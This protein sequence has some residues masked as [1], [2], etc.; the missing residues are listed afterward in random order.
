MKLAFIGF[1]EAARAFRQSI[2]EVAPETTFSAYDILLDSDSGDTMRRAIEAAGAKA[3]ATP[4]EAVL[5]AEWIICAV[6]ADQSHIAAA[7]VAKYLE[8]GQI[9][10]DVNSVAPKR[11]RDNANLVGGNA[12]TYVDMAIMAPVATNR[13]RTPVLVAGNIAGPIEKRLGELEFDFRIVGETPGQA[14]AIKMVRSLFVKGLEAITVETLLAAEA[15]GCA[16]EILSSLEGSYPGLGWPDF[17]EYEF[18]RTLTHGQR[19]EAEMRECAATLKGLGLH[20]ALAEAIAD[21]QGFMG[22]SGRSMPAES[23]L[24]EALPDLV[25][26]RRSLLQNGLSNG[27]HDGRKK[28]ETRL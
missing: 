19:R 5:D 1:G 22:T 9:Y 17:A 15:S 8:K 23:K 21:V 26:R 28:Q 13:H 12:A 7:N 6:T 20:D 16:Q 4:G 18:E 25:I 10:F 27:A 2:A 11:K 24:G 14:T 3:A